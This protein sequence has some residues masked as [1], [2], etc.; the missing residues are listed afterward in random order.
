MNLPNAQI[1]TYRIGQ[2]IFIIADSQ[3]SMVEPAGIYPCSH[4][5]LQ[6][7][8]ELC[9]CRLHITVQIPEI[10]RFIGDLPVRI[11]KIARLQPLPEGGHEKMILIHGEKGA[12]LGQDFLKD[13]IIHEE[14]FL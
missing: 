7:C 9:I 12:A 11:H 5:L 3:R 13:L 6:R 4:K 2:Q 1:R 10:F 14:S 8:A